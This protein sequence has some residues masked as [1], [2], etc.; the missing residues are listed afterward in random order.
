MSEKLTPQQIKASLAELTASIRSHECTTCECT[1][2]YLVQLEMDATD[3]AAALVE[4]LKVSRDRMH[5]CNG[6]KPCPPAS[7][8][9]R[10]LSGDDFCDCDGGD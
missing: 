8:C 7:L 6:C 4:P 5:P 3:E 10:Y 9:A 2:G 1:Q